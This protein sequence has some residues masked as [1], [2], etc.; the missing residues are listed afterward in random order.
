MTRYLVTMVNKYSLILKF[1][2]TF[3]ICEII[4]AIMSYKLEI[5]K[6]IYNLVGHIPKR[7]ILNIFRN[8][9]ISKTTIYRTIS[10]CEQGIPCLNLPKSGRP[11]LLTENRANGICESAKDRVGTSLRKLSRRFNVSHETVR[12]VLQ[13]KGLKYRKRRKCPRYTEDQLRRIPIC[14]RRLR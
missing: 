1:V 2:V 12:R 11:K 8:E 3:R 10:E 9:N 5:R 4:C 13:K 7:E 6:S 14:C